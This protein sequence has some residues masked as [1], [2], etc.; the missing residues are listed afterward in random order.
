MPA[1][2]TDKRNQER[3]QSVLSKLAH[4]DLRAGNLDASG[5]DQVSDYVEFSPDGDTIMFYEDADPLPR[6]LVCLRGADDKTSFLLAETLVKAT[7]MA[8]QLVQSGSGDPYDTT[9]P[10]RIVDLDDAQSYRITTKTTISLIA[11][12][13]LFSYGA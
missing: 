13:P 6:W 3:R 12:R 9:Q 10:E 2:D 4:D 8:E 7:E 5:L 11:P 1:S